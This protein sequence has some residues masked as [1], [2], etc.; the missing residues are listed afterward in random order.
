MSKILKV[1]IIGVGG[2]SNTHIPG[3]NASENAEIVAGCD[4]REDVLKNWGKEH[5]V[6]KLTT[7]PSELFSDPDIDIIDV[8][9]RR[10]VDVNQSRC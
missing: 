3:W 2:I 5:K 7:D 8:Y 1:A 9:S 10:N 6:T 4:I